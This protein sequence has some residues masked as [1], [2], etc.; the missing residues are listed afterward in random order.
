MPRAGHPMRTCRARG[1]AE[2]VTLGTIDRVPARKRIA[3]RAEG[4][5]R[6]ATRTFRRSA[7]TV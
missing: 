2:S 6:N 3:A 7:R 1:R 4:G 5:R